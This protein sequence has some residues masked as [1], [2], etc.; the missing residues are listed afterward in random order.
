M[1]EPPEPF[2]VALR[3]GTRVRI[4]PIRPDDKE[5][6]QQGLRAL[7]PQSRYRR[8]HTPLEAFTTEQLHYLTEI[9]YADHMAWVAERPDR[10]DEPGLGVA[11]Y[12]RL[13]DEPG[14]ADAAVTVVDAYQG[15]GLGS[16]LLAALS[17]SAVAAG[18]AVLRNYVLA[19]NDAM[20][21]LLDELGATRVDEGEGV[22]RVDMP[23]PADPADL[24]DTPAQQVLRAAA[25]RRLPPFRHFLTRLGR[26]P[27]AA[28]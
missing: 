24:A 5:R 7:S 11:R 14:V 16:L 28:G 10:P 25:T 2:D 8:F 20:L 17:R 19:D 12:V 22:Y 1:A 21:A 9:D 27:D 15:R 26:R 6:L 4:R 18:V 23:L 13:P 3:D